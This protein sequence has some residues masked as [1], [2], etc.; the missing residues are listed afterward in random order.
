MLA[1]MLAIR[2]TP[3][4]GVGKDMKEDG[5]GK[6]WPRSAA[7]FYGTN[8][9]SYPGLFSRKEAGHEASCTTRFYCKTCRCVRGGE[10]RLCSEPPGNPD[11]RPWERQN[12]T[13][14]PET[15]HHY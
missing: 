2:Q 13:G 7:K 4:P 12:A 1:T 3:A 5:K 11:L 9:A 10:N 6:R 14:G 15:L 8:I